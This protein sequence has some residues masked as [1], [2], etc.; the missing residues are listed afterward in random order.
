MYRYFTFRSQVT[1]LVH[2]I[3]VCLVCN[4]KIAI[5]NCQQ[6]FPSAGQIVGN[7]L[8]VKRDSLVNALCY[9]VLLAFSFAIL[10][11]NCSEY[12]SLAYLYVSLL[13]MPMLLSK[14]NIYWADLWW[15]TYIYTNWNVKYQ[16]YV[17]VFH[18]WRILF[19][20]SV[21]SFFSWRCFQRAEFDGFQVINQFSGWSNMPHSPLTYMN[22]V[23]LHSAIQSFNLT[24]QV[25]RQPFWFFFC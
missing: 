7:W 19:G 15:E 18:A 1:C 5:A 11:A 12:S 13:F 23:I 17:K 16:W 25:G 21:L 8:P 6:L 14:R 4:A 22:V 9:V 24:N 10:W 3:T 20:V 2:K